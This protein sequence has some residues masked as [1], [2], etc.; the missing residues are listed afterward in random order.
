MS[1]IVSGKRSFFEELSSTPPASKRIRCSSRFASSFPPSSPPLIDQL[2]AI[3]P[4]MD[5]QVLQRALEECGDDLDSAIRSLN[6]LCL[7]PTDRN[8]AAADKTGEGLEGNV[9]LLAQGIATNGD[10]P[11]K[12]QT[13]PEA[14]SIDGSDWVELFVREMLNASNIDDARARASR[15]LEVLEKSIHARAEAEVAQNFHKGNMLL[16]E[17]LE[18]LTQEN[19]ILKRAV[20]LQHERQ[21]EYENQSQELQHLNQ[22]TSQYQEQLRTLEVNNYALTMHLKQAQQSNSIPGRFN[23]DVF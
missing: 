19:T 12:E 10:V 22:V 13:F 2:I 15:S 20:A 17:Q 11:I 1:A 16:K 14:F 5:Q 18:I 3:F 4:E 21:K 8:V 7:V 9:Q 6:E 23:P